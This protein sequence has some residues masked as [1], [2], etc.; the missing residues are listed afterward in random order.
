MFNKH[1]LVVII[2]I[3]VICLNNCYAR[4]NV[5][6]KEIGLEFL[7]ATAGEFAIGIPTCLLIA[8]SVQ[9]GSNV[10]GGGAVVSCLSGCFV[11]G[12]IGAPLG[13]KLIGKTMYQK[14][15]GLG[16]YAGGI[17]GTGL[18]LLSVYLY[19]NATSD[20][21]QNSWPAVIT[22]SLLLPPIL[23]VTGYNLFP[24]KNSSASSMF[25]KYVPQCAVTLRPIE[26]NNK[27]TPEIG[28]KLSLSF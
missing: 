2:L 25:E 20:V 24:S 17:V 4:T 15:S 11:G 5:G 8:Y 16:A 7:G 3:A 14:G 10:H 26:H 13:T 18:G 28:L 12:I 9:W 23:S 19:N 27:I 6:V 22:T 1:Y 21:Q